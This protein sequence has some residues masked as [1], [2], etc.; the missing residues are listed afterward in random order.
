QGRFDLL[1]P[2]HDHLER[3][4]DQD[5]R[6][7]GN[8]GELLGHDLGAL[9][10]RLAQLEQSLVDDVVVQL[11]LLL[12]LE[13]LG[14]LIGEHILDVVKHDVVVLHVERAAHVQRPAER[15]RQLERHAHRPV[16]VG[17]AV[18]AHEEPPAFERPVVPD[19]QDVLLDPTQHPRH[20]A[21]ELRVCLAA[22]PVRADRQ[23]VVLAARPATAPP[24][25]PRNRPPSHAGSS[26]SSRMSFPT[27]RTTPDTTPPGCEY[28]WRPSP[29][30][31]IASR[32]YWRPDEPA[33][34]AAVTTCWR[35]A[36]TGWAAR[37]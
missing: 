32:S 27:P 12:E 7:Q 8:G 34:R 37:H 19:Q 2:L 3:F 29:C 21:T 11:L 30:A 24:P 26:R 15:L 18:H 9:Q 10:V 13:D 23:Q 36:R 4:A 20:D 6:L 35:S 17:R 25:T 14:R 1:G 28:A 5:L 22:Q 33:S 31:P 16:A